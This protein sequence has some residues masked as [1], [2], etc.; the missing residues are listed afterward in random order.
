MRDAVESV[1]RQS[2]PCE[3]I[4]VDDGSTDETV[5][6][7]LAYAG[8]I[9]LVRVEH[10]M[11]VSHAR[12][13]GAAQAHGSLIAFLDSDDLFMPDKL[14]RQTAFMAHGHY[15]ISHTDE[16]WFRDD[17]YVNQGKAHTK[18]GGYIFPKILDKCRISPSSFIIGKELFES[19]GGFDESL[20]VCE[21]YEFFLRLA[22]C[23]EIGYLPE[24]LITKRAVGEG[25][26]SDSIRHIESIRLAILE[27]FALNNALN[28]EQIFYVDRELKRKKN[29]VK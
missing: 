1:F 22:A 11:G 23:H 19:S 27:Q 20:R 24:K 16:Y 26:L 6:G 8:R 29:I 9:Q 25:S 3:V 14:E 10:N 13:I 28:E 4:V 21:D 5:H 17:R 18:Y 7:L 2:M 15:K 12:N